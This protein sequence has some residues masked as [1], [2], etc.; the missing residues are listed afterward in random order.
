MLISSRQQAELIGREVLG[1]YL[2]QSAPEPAG[3]T[4]R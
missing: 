3:G 4:P 2:E 1:G